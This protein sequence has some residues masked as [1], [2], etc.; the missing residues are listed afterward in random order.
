MKK[1]KALYYNCKLYV[2]KVWIWSLWQSTHLVYMVRVLTT[3][4]GQNGHIVLMYILF[5]KNV[6]R[7]RIET[8]GISRKKHVIFNYI[9]C[10][11]PVREGLWLGVG[12]MSYFFILL[13]N[14][15]VSFE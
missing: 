11:L 10:H 7:Q 5:F 12:A 13:E 4:C 15:N 3:G 8:D 6:N 14:F 2:P 9:L 1:N